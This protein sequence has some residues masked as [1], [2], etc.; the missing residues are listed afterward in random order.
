MHFTFYTFMIK[1]FFFLN[2]KG[3]IY[4][5]HLHLYNVQNSLPQSVH[6]NLLKN[7]IND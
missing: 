6:D 1:V 2:C 4:C 7:L 3:K 5:G